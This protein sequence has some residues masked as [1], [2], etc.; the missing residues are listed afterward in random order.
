[1]AAQVAEG[2][3]EKRWNTHRSLRSAR[4]FW[5]RP[6][7]ARHKRVHQCKAANTFETIAL[8]AA[9]GFCLIARSS[10]PIMR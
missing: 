10:S 6:H 3:G 9:A 8:P 4:Q 7:T 5:T 2:H 1:M